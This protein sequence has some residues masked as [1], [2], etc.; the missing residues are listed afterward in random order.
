MAAR[1]LFASAPKEMENKLEIPA[2]NLIFD[3]EHRDK[4][5]IAEIAN[6]HGI[7]LNI[8]SANMH[9]LNGKT[10]GQML[11]ETAIAV[12]TGKSIDDLRMVRPRLIERESTGPC[13][14]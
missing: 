10:Y 9:R 7:K 2:L 12:S 4:P 1:R 8:L 11:I 5:I 14:K 3:G 6:K 13:K